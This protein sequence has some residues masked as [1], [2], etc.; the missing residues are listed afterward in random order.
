MCDERAE[1]GCLE[2]SL[3]DGL[4]Q[5]TIPTSGSDN[6]LHIKWL[7]GVRYDLTQENRFNWCV[8]VVVSMM[9]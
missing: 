4:R 9:W 2:V 1:F 5:L 3:G 7:D 6:W 8:H